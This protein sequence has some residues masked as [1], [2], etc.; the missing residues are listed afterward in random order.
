MK[1]T[2]LGCGPLTGVPAIGPNWGRC[3]PADPRNRRRRD[4][5]LV[6]LGAVAIPFDMAHAPADRRH[7][8][9]DG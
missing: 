5:L 4:S 6:E 3:D 2:I 1:V 9:T 8:S 7:G